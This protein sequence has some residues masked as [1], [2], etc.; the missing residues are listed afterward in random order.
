MCALGVGAVSKFASSR[1]CQRRASRPA[2]IITT[3][4]I[5][6]TA[7]AALPTSEPLY[8]QALCSPFIIR[9][10]SDPCCPEGADLSDVSDSPDASPPCDIKINGVGSPPS[11]HAIM[12]YLAT[13]HLSRAIIR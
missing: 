12:Y 3:C 5:R 9:S 8:P 11:Y 4:E 6:S 1:S 13:K 2:N 10:V 7:L